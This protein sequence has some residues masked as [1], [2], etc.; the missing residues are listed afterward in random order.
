MGHYSQ[1][2]FP[3]DCD[4]IEPIIIVIDCLVQLL[5]LGNSEALIKNFNAFMRGVSMFCYVPHWLKTDTYTSAHF[6]FRYNFMLKNTSF[7][8]IW[9][10]CQWQG[11]ATGD[12]WDYQRCWLYELGTMCCWSVQPLHPRCHTTPGLR[13][14]AFSPL[15]STCRPASFWTLFLSLHPPPISLH[16]LKSFQTL[17]WRNWLR[18][19]HWGWQPCWWK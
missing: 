14:W 8:K 6:S 15:L 2:C 7:L 4:E 3:K 13:T 17:L 16:F 1:H 11:K 19:T 10:S 5:S 18:C 12:T 9:G